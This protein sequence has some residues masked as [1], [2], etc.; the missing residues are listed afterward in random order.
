MMGPDDGEGATDS[1]PAD[2]T[3]PRRDFLAR[4]VATV[5]A[6]G[7]A[8][9]APGTGKGAEAAGRSASPATG[10][11]AS[12]TAAPGAGSPAYS[13]R[14]EGE[15]LNRV[16]FP[17][18]R[19]RRGDDLPRGHRRAVPRLAPEPARTSSTSRAS[20]PRSPSRR[21]AAPGGARPRGPGPGLEAVR[22]AGLRRT[23]PRAPP[24]ACRGSRRARFR[25]RFPFAG[26]RARGRR[27]PLRVEITAGARSRRATPTARACPSPAL[28]YRFRNPAAEPLEAVFSFNA[29][30]FLAVRA[31]RTRTA[32]ARPCRGASSSGVGR[33][34]R[35]SP[36]KA[37]AAPPSRAMP[38]ARVEPRL[39]PRRLVGPAH[40]GL[41]GRGGGRGYERRR[42]ARGSRPR[43]PRSS[44]R[45]PWRRA[46]RGRSGPQLAWYAGQT[47]LRLGEDP[48]ARR[49]PEARAHLPSLV[50][51]PVLRSRRGGG[52]FARALRRAAGED[53]PLLATASTTPRCPPR[54]SR[55]WPPT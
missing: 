36:G 7:A 27:V 37:A 34:A 2:S 8:G 3:I 54:W 13:G 14:Y 50:C 38:G 17:L 22:R 26:H 5:G 45:S 44:C 32:S 52:L 31:T 15:R 19:H 21:G 33:H 20:S 9:A 39:V 25:A 24:T 12:F 46:S 48:P 55:R 4:S 6:I 16:A 42:H 43:G 18:G 1:L 40:H 10:P 51:G 53:G 35:T 41:A 29:R 28:E 23:A 11:A 30:N 47:D 49:R